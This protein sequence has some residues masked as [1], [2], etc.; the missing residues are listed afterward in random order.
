MNSWFL[1]ICLWCAF[2]GEQPHPTPFEIPDWFK[3]SFLNLED[4]IREAVTQN[5]RLMIFVHQDNCFYCAKFIQKNLGLPEIRKYLQEHFDVI[6]INLL[7]NREISG[8]NSLGIDRPVTERQFCQHMQI[9]ATPTLLF[10]D[11]AGK[12]A[13]HLSGYIE[14]PQFLTAMR[15]ITEKEKAEK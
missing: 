3:T 5:K 8:A 13:L 6:D 1:A 4:D 9:W 10:L 15:N 7:G 2:A 12:V 14:P 11:T